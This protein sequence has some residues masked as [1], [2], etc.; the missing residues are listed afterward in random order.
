M[1]EPPVEWLDRMSGVEPWRGMLDVVEATQPSLEILDA[2]QPPSAQAVHA[3]TEESARAYA[4]A[5]S[6][7]TDRLRELSPCEVSKLSEEEI[8]RPAKEVIGLSIEAGGD[9]GLQTLLNVAVPDKTSAIR[10]AGRLLVDRE[11]T[12][13]VLELRREKAASRDGRWPEKLLNGDSRVCPGAAY[14]YRSRGGAMSIRF[15]GAIDDPGIPDR[16]LPLSFEIRAP[17]P[18]PTPGRARRLTVTPRPR[19]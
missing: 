8:W 7:T 14:E 12:A 4:R 16:V 11:L 6:A 19:A 2:L 3:A 5:W 15:M 9:P 18:T 13:K 17:R 10:R 1:S